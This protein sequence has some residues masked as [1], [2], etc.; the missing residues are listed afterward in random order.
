MTAMPRRPRRRRPCEV[1]CGPH[2][3]TY[4]RLYVGGWLCD[5]HS[6]WARAGRPEP[7]PGP[8]WPIHR[9]PATYQTKEEDQ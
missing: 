4:A 1:P 2:S 6:P 9:P 3:L 8:G 7:Q 5:R